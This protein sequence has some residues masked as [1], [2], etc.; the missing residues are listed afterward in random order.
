MMLSNSPLISRDCV[1]VGVSLPSWQE[2]VRAV[3]RLLVQSQ[4]AEEAY[5]EAMV[6]MAEEMG[7]YIVITTGIAIP[8]ARPEEGA[9]KVGFAAIQL[10]PPLFFGNPEND[11][12]YLVIGFCTP[13]A[14][15][16]VALLSRI[17]RLIGQDGFP[18][19]VKDVRTADELAEIFNR[20]VPDQ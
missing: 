17:A 10:D 6:R 15:A 19:Q 12:V 4:A 5:I 9:L 8:H 2:A 11:P 16:H 18:D 1:G 7:P 20:T 3:G 13:N 14:S